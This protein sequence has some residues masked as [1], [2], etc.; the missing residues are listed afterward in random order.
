IRNSNDKD[1][2][3]NIDGDEDL[4]YLEDAK[5]LIYKKKLFLQGNDGNNKD[6]YD[7][8][9][10]FAAK[11]GHNAEP[12]NHNDIGS[13]IY[14]VGDTTLFTDLGSGLYSKKYFGSERYQIL[15]TGSQGHSVPIV[16]GDFQAD[17][18]EFSAKIYDFESSDRKVFF[19]LDIKGAYD[20]GNLLSLIRSFTINSVDNTLVLEDKYEFQDKPVSI[21]ERFISFYKAKLK[22][23]GRLILEAEKD[24]LE[25]HYN[26]QQL[27]F[28]CSKDYHINHHGEKESVYLLDFLVKHPGQEE[29]VQIKFIPTSS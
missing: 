18:H 8:D 15:C 22:E 7:R 1:I 24:L 28:S 4:Y 12:H 29:V 6:S 10:V 20:N 14:H 26:Q 9:L 21:I 5:W 19:S 13:F 23:N 2:D 16:E 25:I 27:D 17:G 11:G 3:N